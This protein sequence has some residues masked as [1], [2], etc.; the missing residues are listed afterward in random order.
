MSESTKMDCVELGRSVHGVG[1]IVLCPIKKGEAI[2]LWRAGDWKIWRPR[3]FD[4]LKW[5]NK[6]C[7][8]AWD[9]FYGPADPK[10]M[11]LAWFVNHSSKPN[12]VCS[13]GKNG[14]WKFVALRNIKNGEEVTV[15]YSTLDY[16]GK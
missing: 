4:Q 1:V 13:Y 9:E 14:N 16:Y 8:Y 5:C 2:G 3:T 12:A 7:I 10:R 6:W 15:N 11:S